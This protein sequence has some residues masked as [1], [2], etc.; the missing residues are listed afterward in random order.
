MNPMMRSI[1]DRHNEWI[2]LS[3]KGYEERLPLRPESQLA[4]LVVQIDSILFEE[5]QVRL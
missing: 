2:S 1:V 3:R 5:P 4:Y